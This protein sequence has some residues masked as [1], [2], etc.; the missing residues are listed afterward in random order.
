MSRT[1]GNG[2]VKCWGY[3]AYGQVGDDSITDRSV[4]VD[5]FGLSSEASALALGNYAPAHKGLGMIYQHLDFK[6]M[7]IE[8]FRQYLALVPGAADVKQRILER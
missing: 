6:Q 1:G 5:V 4:P 3:N 2:G 7:A 8:E